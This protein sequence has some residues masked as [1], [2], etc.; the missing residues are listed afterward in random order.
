MDNKQLERVI[1]EHG[2]KKYCYE[3]E[4]LTVEQAELAREV[5]EWKYNQIQFGTDSLDK[6]YNSRG[7]DYLTII[8]S[9]LLR[10]I[11]D[12][13]EVKAFSRAKANGEVQD[14]I[15]ELPASNLTAL[16]ECVEDFF[17]NTGKQ[18]IGSLILQGVKKRSG[19][20][21]LLPLL[22]QMQEKQL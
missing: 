4:L 14:F 13:G 6:L 1:F 16:R 18:Q 8:L 15:K 3:F 2:G 5:G 12:K 19:I 11:D 10:E 9:Y 22:Q 20:E 17:Y 21:I 7:A